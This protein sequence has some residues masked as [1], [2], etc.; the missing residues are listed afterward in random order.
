MASKSV[1]SALPGAY[2]HSQPAVAWVRRRSTARGV[3]SIWEGGEKAAATAAPKK[4]S[5]YIHCQ[6]HGGGLN[7]NRKTIVQTREIS[8]KEVEIM[9]T[10]FVP[11]FFF[12]MINTWRLFRRIDF[13]MFAHLK[14]YNVR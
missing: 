4:S 3:T 14:L 13:R 10:T 7:D 1:A 6:V 12:A 9:Q 8:R 2:K 11:I 5:V